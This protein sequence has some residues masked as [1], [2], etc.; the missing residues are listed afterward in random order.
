MYLRAATCRDSR[1]FRHIVASK[2]RARGGYCLLNLM[3]VPA[4]MPNTA[5]INTTD[6]INKRSLPIAAQ[7]TMKIRLSKRQKMQIDMS[8]LL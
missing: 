6:V 5:I 4:V 8:L 7:Y 1:D 2:D 3:I